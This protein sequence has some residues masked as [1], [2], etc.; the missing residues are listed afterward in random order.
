MTVYQRI[1]DRLLVDPHFHYKI[2]LLYTVVGYV[3]CR[4]GLEV[5]QLGPLYLDY[6]P[7]SS[8]RDLYYNAKALRGVVR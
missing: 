5:S 7:F 6:V 2:R 4:T 3:A 1:G 8:C